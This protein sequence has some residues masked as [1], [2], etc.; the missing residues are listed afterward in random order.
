MVFPNSHLLVTSIWTYTGAP[1]EEGQFGLRFDTDQLPD[2]TLIDQIA[3]AVQF[4][5]VTANSSIPTNFKLARVKAAVIQPDGKYPETQEP[6]IHDFSPTVSGGGVGASPYPLQV[7]HVASLL[8]GAERGRAHRGR[9][10]L[11]PP[12]VNLSGDQW[13]FPQTTC[14]NRATEF[15]GLIDVLNGT[16][17]APCMVFSSVGAGTKRAV[18]AVAVGNRPDIQRRRAAQLTDVYSEAAVDGL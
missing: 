3:Q 6:A 12:V 16:I 1:Q 5:W 2:Q 11:P 18:T 4:F 7:A 9:V 14:A 15:A 8:T 17:L 10:Y 13:S